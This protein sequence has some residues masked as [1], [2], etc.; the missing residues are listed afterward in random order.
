MVTDI[1]PVDDAVFVQGSNN[2]LC[3]QFDEAIDELPDIV[4]TLWRENK[5]I[6]KW[7]K[8]DMLIDDDTIVC[9]I[10]A[11][12]TAAMIPTPHIIQIKALD[13][14][15]YTIIYVALKINVVPRND[16]GIELTAGE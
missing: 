13:E 2:P 1:I 11:E 12:E 4:V 8:A 6:K 16:S 5:L 10:S 7:E 14:N 3:V 15:G 9:P